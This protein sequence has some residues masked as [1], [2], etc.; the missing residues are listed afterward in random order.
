MASLL[1]S[2]R[3]V[4]VPRHDDVDIALPS[5]LEGPALERRRGIYAGPSTHF[6]V[7]AFEETVE[8]AEPQAQHPTAAPYGGFTQQPRS[9]CRPFSL[10]TMREQDP[11]PTVLDQKLIPGAHQR[12]SDP[13]VVAVDVVVLR[14][15]EAL[16][17][18]AVARSSGVKFLR[19]S[20]W[21][22]RSQRLPDVSEQHDAVE[23]ALQLPQKAK[24]LAIV[25]P[26]GIGATSSS[27]MSIRYDC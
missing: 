19:L 15:L 23:G 2:R 10:M 27:E 16:R 21:N 12:S 4:R 11:G 13:V 22:V 7:D 3:M 18:F 17:D 25:V 9:R 20:T 24:K 26:E 8:T 1:R 6:R 14:V 5:G